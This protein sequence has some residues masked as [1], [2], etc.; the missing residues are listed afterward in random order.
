VVAKSNFVPAD[1]ASTV[2]RRGRARNFHKQRL[3]L[4]QRRVVKPIHRAR[5]S[6]R[7]KEEERGKV[8][9][10]A[11]DREGSRD[12]ACAQKLIINFQSGAFEPLIFRVGGRK[13]KKKL[14]S[15]LGNWAEQFGFA[16]Q[17]KPELPRSHA[18]PT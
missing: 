11:I 8:T 14:M 4:G 18:P 6:R 3:T 9:P 7:A 15:C 10:T 2:G 12:A 1:A 5:C 16:L 17:E 13:K